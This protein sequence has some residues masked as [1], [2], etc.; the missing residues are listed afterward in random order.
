MD[1][2]TTTTLNVPKEAGTFVH[3]EAKVINAE[4]RQAVCTV[5]MALNMPIES[6]EDELARTMD[7]LK[8]EL[9]EVCLRYHN[10]ISQYYGYGE[11]E[12]MELPLNDPRRS[13]ERPLRKWR[14]F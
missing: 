9:N 4:A 11:E 8:D 1:C 14:P 5:A 13:L 6:T 2:T 10:I 12:Q 3:V 7:L